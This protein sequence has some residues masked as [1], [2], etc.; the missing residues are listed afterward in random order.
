MS[1]QEETAL[2]AEIKHIFDSG[3]NEVRVFEMVRNGYTPNSRIP[4]NPESILIRLTKIRE[5]DNPRHP[6]NIEEGS[7]IE[8][9]IGRDYFQKP[10][11]G[12]A[13]YFGVT[14]RTS[15]VQEVLSSNTFRTLNSVYMWEIIG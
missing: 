4:Y 1:T 6:N 3:A 7:V 14:Y 5:A 12:E 9:T 11:I 10:T 8:K 15:I 2:K 13:F